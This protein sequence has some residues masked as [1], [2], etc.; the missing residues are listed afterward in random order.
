RIAAPALTAITARPAVPANADTLPDPPA[1]DI[2]TDRIDLTNDLVA[3]DAGI[4]DARVV[5]LDGR[6]VAVTDAAGQHADPHLVTPRFGQFS[7]LLMEG[8]TR[9]RDNHHRHLRHKS[10][11]RWRYA[12]LANRHRDRIDRAR[13]FSAQH[14]GIGHLSRRTDPDTLLLEIFID[15]FLAALAPQA[16]ALVAAKRRHETD[17]T[18][19]VDP[20]GTGTQPLGHQ[21]RTPDVLCPH[22]GGQAVHRIVGNRDRLVLICE[23]NDG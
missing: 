23:R 17:R 18:V 5:P 2:S 1:I 21:Q 20:D 16:A 14:E 7:F 19:G 22:T 8:R 13:P 15:C 9:L 3:W 11:P 12:N 6:G 10:A 4:A